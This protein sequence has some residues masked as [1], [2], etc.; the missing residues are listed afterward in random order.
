MGKKRLIYMLFMML[1][2]ALGVSQPVE[3]KKAK[4]TYKVSVSTKPLKGQYQQRAA[5]DKKAKTTYMLRSYMEKLAKDG[6][7]TLVL[8]KGTYKIYENLYV[9]SNTTIRFE[10]GVKL[11]AQ[12]RASLS[13]IFIPMMPSKTTKANYAKGYKAAKNA[14]GQI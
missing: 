2:L 5:N 8:K 7:G 1:I 4:K 3:A 9:P 12:N 10:K 6:G 13:S 14:I 11:V